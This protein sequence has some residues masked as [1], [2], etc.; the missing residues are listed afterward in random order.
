M[1][2]A[3]NIMKKAP[4][5]MVFEPNITGKAPSIVVFEPNIMEKSTECNGHYRIAPIE[6]RRTGKCK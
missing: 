4:N 5:I 6:K 1:E 3:P 2:K